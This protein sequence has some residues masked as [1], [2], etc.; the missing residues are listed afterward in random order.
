MSLSIDN[1]IYD[2]Q[3]FLETTMKAIV[4]CMIRPLGYSEMMTGYPSALVSGIP[5]RL[6]GNKERK[7][8]DK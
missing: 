8:G 1:H 4:G 3:H 6:S 2:Y 7:F 5:H